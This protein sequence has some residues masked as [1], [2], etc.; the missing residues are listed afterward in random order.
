MAPFAL[1]GDPVACGYL[2]LSETGFDVKDLVKEMY[3]DPG[4]DTYKVKLRKELFVAVE[5]NSADSSCIVGPRLSGQPGDVVIPSV[6]TAH[7]HAR[8]ARTSL[9]LCMIV[10]DSDDGC[11][12]RF[13][14]SSGSSKTLMSTCQ[15][16]VGIVAFSTGQLHR[17]CSIELNEGFCG[18]ADC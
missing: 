12:T 11:N 2:L 4:R 13:H 18:G 5:D 15:E 6:E 1:C 17:T 3:H 16:I 10:G 9:A 8:L 7:D 14:L